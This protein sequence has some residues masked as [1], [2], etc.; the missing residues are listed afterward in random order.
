MV[1]LCADREVR[2]RRAVETYAQTHPLVVQ[3]C[4]TESTTKRPFDVKACV[5]RKLGTPGSQ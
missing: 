2:A 4:L 5:E 1:K 3:G